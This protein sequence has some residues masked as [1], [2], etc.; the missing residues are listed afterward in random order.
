MSHTEDT[1]NNKENFDNEPTIETSDLQEEKVETTVEGSDIEVANAQI[2]ELS[3]Q[4]KELRE[5]VLR[6]QAEF[7]NFRKR[8]LKEK[9]DIILPD[10]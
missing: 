7:D 1:L 2:E 5:K 10:Q 3:A 9:S 4:V 8:T 6:Q